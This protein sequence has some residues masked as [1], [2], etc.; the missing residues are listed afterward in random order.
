MHEHEQSFGDA[1]GRRDRQEGVRFRPASE[2]LHQDESFTGQRGS[3]RVPHQERDVAMPRDAR[4]QRGRLWMHDVLWQLGS[5]ARANRRGG[6]EERPCCG[7]SAQRKPQLRGPHTSIDARQLF[8]LAA[9]RSGVCS[10]GPNRHRLRDG[11]N[12]V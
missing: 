11:A 4:L 5:A 1:G 7:R 10:S 2:P 9:A 6:R 3:H 8:G 12:R